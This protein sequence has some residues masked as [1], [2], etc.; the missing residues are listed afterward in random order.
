MT[1]NAGDV[2]LVK[3][4]NLGGVMKTREE[5]VMIKKKTLQLSTEEL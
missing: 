2:L 3:R 5:I 4:P 1:D